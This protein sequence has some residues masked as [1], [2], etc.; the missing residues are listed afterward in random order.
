MA[1]NLAAIRDRVEQ[2]LEDTANAIWSTGALDEAIRQALVEYIEHS[3]YIKDSEITLAAD[4]RQIDISELT[5]LLSVQEVYWP[6]SA[7]YWPPNQVLQYRV[8]WA[9]GTPYLWFASHAGAEPKT[10]EVVRVRYTTA[11]TIE[12]LDSATATTIPDAHISKLVI[13]AAGYALVFA[14]IDRAT[15]F[16]LDA[17]TVENL[18]IS[19]NAY[20]KEFRLW[21]T[22]LGRAPGGSPFLE[23]GGWRLDEWD[24]G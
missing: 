9:A 12:D 11:H 1:N 18:R 19:G 10:G 17:G 23:V 5:G 4:G 24:Q 16:N 14:A 21:L 20:I 15:E 6:Y 2:A 7:S 13:G 22:A 3:P 8:I